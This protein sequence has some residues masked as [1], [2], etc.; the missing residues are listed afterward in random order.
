MEINLVLNGKPQRFTAEPGETLLRLLRRLGARVT[1]TVDIATDRE[2]DS[3][4][5]A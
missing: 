4:A 1:I 2:D 3:S 5:Q